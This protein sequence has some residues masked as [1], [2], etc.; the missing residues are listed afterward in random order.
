MGIQ[1]MTSLFMKFTI[2]PS[3][4]VPVKQEI[5]ATITGH[6]KV[7]AKGNKVLYERWALNCPQVLVGGNH[8]KT[9]SVQQVDLYKKQ[10][11]FY[12]AINTLDVNNNQSVHNI[13]VKDVQYTTGIFAS[14]K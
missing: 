7:S 5:T 2:E 1:K 6:N 8:E 13:S 12:L 11:E 3:A 10:G 14:L 9:A 4:D